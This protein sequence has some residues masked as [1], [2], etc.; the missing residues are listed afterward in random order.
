MG[1]ADEPDVQWAQSGASGVR[2]WAY[3]GITRVH[4]RDPEE[5]WLTLC[6]VRIPN[7]SRLLF[8]TQEEAADRVVAWLREHDQLERQEPYRH[9][10][11]HCERCGTRVEPLI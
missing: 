10:V 9:S 2:S 5:P 4:R 6:G 11:G 8:V 1:R 7:P 3:H